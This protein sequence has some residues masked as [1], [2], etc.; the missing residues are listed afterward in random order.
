[1]LLINLIILKETLMEWLNFLEIISWNQW[2]YD[3]W[4]VWF[5]FGWILN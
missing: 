5:N 4:K 1:M 3:F 2:M